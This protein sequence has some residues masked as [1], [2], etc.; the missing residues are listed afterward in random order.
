MNL[1]IMKFI[2]KEAGLHVPNLKK[3]RYLPITRAVRH[4]YGATSLFDLVGEKTGVTKDLKTRFPD[5][6][7]Q[8]QSI[9]YYLILDDSNPLSHCSR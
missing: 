4:F 1:G 7:R 3:E 9:T 5:S 8:I 2:A 6:Y